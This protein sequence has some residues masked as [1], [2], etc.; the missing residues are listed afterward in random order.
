MSINISVNDAL[1]NAMNIANNSKKSG[2]IDIDL[3][4]PDARSQ[5]NYTTKDCICS[6]GVGTTQSVAAGGSYTYTGYLNEGTPSAA[7]FTYCS[8]KPN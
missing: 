7:K 2:Y 4:P 6:K 3:C 8:T 5:V 1:N